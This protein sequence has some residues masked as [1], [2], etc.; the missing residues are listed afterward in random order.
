M[1]SL[2]LP[3]VILIAVMAAGPAAAATNEEIVSQVRATETAF[4]KTMASRDVAAFASYVSDEAVFFDDKDV[5]RGKAAVVAGWKP[6][7]EGPRAPFSWEPDQVE[8]LASGTLALST[9]PVRDPQGRPI[10]TFSSIWRRDADG[11]WR[12]VFD[13]GCPP[14]DCGKKH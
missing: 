14:C 11:R 13:K 1:R 5:L 9:G 12:I 3:M 2:S 4:A 8:V 6:L 10:G 7:F